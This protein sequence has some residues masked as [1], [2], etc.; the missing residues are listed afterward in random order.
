MVSPSFHLLYCSFANRLAANVFTPVNPLLPLPQTYSTYKFTEKDTTFSN[1]AYSLAITKNFNAFSIT[2]SINYAKLNGYTQKGS[3]LSV[4][5]FPKKNLNLYTTT[6]IMAN[7]DNGTTKK[8]AN[9]LVGFKVFTFLWTELQG[10][11]GDLSNGMEGNGFLV[12]NNP[13]KSMLRG[14]ANLIFSFKHI[15]LSIRYQ[16]IQMQTKS[17]ISSLSPAN[18]FSVV[19]STQ[20]YNYTNNTL[21][22]GIKW[23]L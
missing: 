5:L 22:G 7:I 14:G 19:N 10:G 13:D 1:F 6:T 12:Y 21:I 4:S 17:Y 18:N 2:P 20:I 15:E 11:Y 23:N 3:A 8:F 16:Y 9:Q